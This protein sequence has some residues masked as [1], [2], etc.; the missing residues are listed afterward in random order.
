ME[1][2]HAKKLP[3]EKEQPSQFEEVYEKVKSRIVGRTFNAVNWMHLVPICMEVTNT[4]NRSSEMVENLMCKLILEI[5]MDE[6][7]DRFVARSIVS[8]VIPALVKFQLGMNE[9]VTKLAGELRPRAFTMDSSNYASV[10]YGECKGMMMHIDGS[11]S[12]VESAFEQLQNF[13]NVQKDEV[14]KERL[15]QEQLESE[16]NRFEK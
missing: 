4:D 9:L 6:E 13:T 5:P 8:C 10:N 11:M 12:R 1:D 14:N 15:R 2:F 3:S 7:A 16:I